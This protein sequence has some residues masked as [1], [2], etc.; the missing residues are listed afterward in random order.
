[1]Y[2][3]FQSIVSSLEETC[4]E[5]AV[6]WLHL[7]KKNKQ[8]HRNNFRRGSGKKEDLKETRSRSNR[9]WGKNIKGL[10]KTKY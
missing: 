6:V 7:S 4:C 2:L 10:K 5:M 9:Q 3:N 1:M 8:K